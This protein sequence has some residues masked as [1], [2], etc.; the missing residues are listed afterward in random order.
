M[1]G[2]DAPR[3]GRLGLASRCRPD[4]PAD[5]STSHRRYLERARPGNPALMTSQG[6]FM[7]ARSRS[8]DLPP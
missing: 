1:S 6:K 3:P 7:A 4:L 8:E 2:P 5:V